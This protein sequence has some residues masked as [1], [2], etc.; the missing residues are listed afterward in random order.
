VKSKCL[1]SRRAISCGWG[2]FTFTI[3]SAK[4]KVAAASG[5]MLAPA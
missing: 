5:A 1:G 2:S 4:A 3:M